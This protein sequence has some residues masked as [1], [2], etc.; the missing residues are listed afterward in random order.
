MKNK[1]SNSALDCYQ[2]CP[3]K[4]EFQYVQRLKADVT[5]TPLLFGSAI[6]SALNYILES[7]RDKKEWNKE[8]AH[9][10][11]Q[12]KMEEWLKVRNQLD[13]FKNECPAEL[14]DSDPEDPDIQLCVW[15][16]IVSRGHKCLDI[17]IYEVL[18]L[19]DEVLY[20]QN[21]F[22][23]EN[24]DGD[25]FTGVIDFIAKLKDGRVV[26][27]DNKTASAK[28]PKNKVVKSQQLSF[29]QDQFPDISLCGYIVLIKNP[30]KEKGLQFQILIDE[31][32][33]S[34]KEH[35]FKLLD[36]TMKKIKNKE[37]PCNPK[38]CKAFGKTCEYAAACQWDDYSGLISNKSVD[39]K[40]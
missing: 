34:T 10:I 6:D 27:L 28:Y 26:L 33:E 24:E 37:F 21:K 5:R 2:L 31:I 32:P 30:E 7:I 1:I 29:Y 38:G 17:Y 22:D 3:K 23:I 4:Y 35:S 14:Q 40:E 13:Y 9:K 20:V 19:I 15:H 25:V 8:E 16:N 18:P 36:E 11:F 12:A 39:K